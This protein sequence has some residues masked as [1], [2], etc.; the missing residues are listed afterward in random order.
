MYSSTVCLTLHLAS[1]VPFLDSYCTEAIWL[2]RG[3]VF[4]EV[5]YADQ[6]PRHRTLKPTNGQNNGIDY[7]A[8][9]SV[10]PRNNP[11]AF[12]RPVIW[13]AA[14]QGRIPTTPPNLGG[15]LAF[16][17][18][19]MGRGKREIKKIANAASRQ[20]TFFK[21]RG[22]LFKKAKE[23]AVLCDASVGVIVISATGKLYSY[24]SSKVSAL[25][26]KLVHSPKI[27]QVIKEQ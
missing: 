4:G 20:V 9:P 6:Y 5:E 15:V 23:L 24:S 26:S 2:P 27:L 3:P 25:V 14:F 19:D 1:L 21:R 12:N 8:A 22:G 17:F 16:K 11:R 7:W 18:V 10:P 13:T